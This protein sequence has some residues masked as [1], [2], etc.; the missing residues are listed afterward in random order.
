VATQPQ[1][2]TPMDP[3]GQSHEQLESVL[4]ATPHE[5]ESRILRSRLYRRNE[6]APLITAGSPRCSLK[7]RCPGFCPQ[8]CFRGSPDGIGDL[9]GH[10][11]EHGVRHVQVPRPHACGGARLPPLG[12]HHPRY[13][14]FSCDRNRRRGAL[15]GSAAHR[16]STC[17]LPTRSMPA[18]PRRVGRSRGLP[19]DVALGPRRP[20]LSPIS[21]RT[22]LRP[23]GRRSARSDHRDPWPPTHRR[24]GLRT[25]PSSS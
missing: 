16:P 21:S 17:A 24:E 4:G 14:G 12:R 13:R 23:A 8:G 5:F 1:V 20:A 6:A 11:L 19:S 9:P 10:L 3:A 7:H 25:S 15:D 2:R 18:S 22:R